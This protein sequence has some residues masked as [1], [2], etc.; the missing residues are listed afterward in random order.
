MNGLTCDS[1]NRNQ[2]KEKVT[3]KINRLKVGIKSKTCTNIDLKDH[4][5][6]VMTVRNKRSKE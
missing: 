6:T 2:K 1:R 3:Y 4:R 5:K